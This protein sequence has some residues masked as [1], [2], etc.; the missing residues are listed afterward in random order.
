MVEE[1]TGTWCG[2]CPDGAL[3][4]D[5]LESQNAG[6]VIGASFHEG[7]P[8]QITYFS[9]LDATYGPVNSYPSG[10]VN[11]VPMG[12]DLLIGRESWASAANI[13]LTKTASCGLAMTSYLSSDKKTVTVTVHCGFNTTLSGDYRVT[14]YM[15]E[16]KVTGYPQ[17]NYYNDGSIDPNS[18][19]VGLGDP[20]QD[21][22]HNNVV[23]TS[24]STDLG[25]AIPS[26][27]MVQGGEYIVTK[28]GSV[29]GFNTTNMHIRS[30]HH[31]DW[32]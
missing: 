10:M 5:N 17:A 23:R 21:W 15:T 6:K 26:S 8:L 22:D 24:L 29:D 9:T 12:S 18:P 1:F 28:S 11:R 31:K 3:V 20:I 32:Y 2:Y 14:I 13:Q 7:D 19:L 4:L 27:K 30:L 25:D 16:D